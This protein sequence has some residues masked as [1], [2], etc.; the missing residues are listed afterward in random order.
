MGYDED[1]T[2]AH[3]IYWAGA[4]KISVERSIRF[5][6]DSVAIPI[7]I[8]RPTQSAK[9]SIQPVP[10]PPA[11]T[12]SGEEE[13]EVKDKLINPTPAPAVAAPHSNTGQHGA[14]AV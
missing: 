8:P 1:S 11:T 3:R 14:Q 10:Q 4:H 7:L 6:P 12:D 5:M 9:P 13:V 2:H